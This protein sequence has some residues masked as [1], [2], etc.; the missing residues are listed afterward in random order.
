MLCPLGEMDCRL[1]K[2]HKV[3]FIRSCLCSNINSAGSE[4][5]WATRTG[6][7]KITATAA[8]AD[9]SV[10]PPSLRRRSKPSEDRSVNRRFVGTSDGRI[11]ILDATSGYEVAVHQASIYPFYLCAHQ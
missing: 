1:G 6:K 4:L 7:D 2:R 3:V 10:L 5:V 9:Y 11:V 8:E